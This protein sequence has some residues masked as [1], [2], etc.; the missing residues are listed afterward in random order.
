[1]LGGGEGWK[2]GVSGGARLAVVEDLARVLRVKVL[3]RGPGVCV[4]RRAAAQG[5]R[6]AATTCRPRPVGGKSAGRRAGEGGVATGAV[7]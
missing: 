4:K 2:T 1:M 7:G 5:R 3:R 6:A